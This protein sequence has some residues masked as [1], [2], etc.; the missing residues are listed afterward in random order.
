V[1][2]KT[3]IPEQDELLTIDEVR[4]WLRVGRTRLNGLLQSGELPSFK[5]GRRRF[6][7][8]G[9]VSDWLYQHRYQPGE[10]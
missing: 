7:R 9:D 5:L 2:L 6:V 8:R 3:Q 4:A 1:E 10:N